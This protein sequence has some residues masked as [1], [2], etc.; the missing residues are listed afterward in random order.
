MR[1]HNSK[2]VSNLGQINLKLRVPRYRTCSVEHGQFGGK[3]AACFAS[4]QVGDV[5]H[6]A[7]LHI[8]GLSKLGVSRPI[9]IVSSSV[10]VG[11]LR[12]QYERI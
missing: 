6:G 11:P 10:L 1:V 4:S 8:Y 12:E 5:R 2:Q 9:N 3:F 7:T